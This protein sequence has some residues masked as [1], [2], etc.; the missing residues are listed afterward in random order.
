MFVFASFSLADFAISILNFSIL[1][2]VSERAKTGGVSNIL[3]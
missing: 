1:N 2:S 3:C